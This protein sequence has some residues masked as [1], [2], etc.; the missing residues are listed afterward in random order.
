[1]GQT[2]TLNIKVAPRRML[3]PREAAEYCGLPLKRFPS[4][5]A[6]P[7]VLM[8]D[9][10]KLYDLRD[11][12]AWLDALKGGVSSEDEILRRLD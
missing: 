11:L 5:C 3:S 9:G 1:M 8:P 7:P 2:A 10:A 6:V 4:S 12:D